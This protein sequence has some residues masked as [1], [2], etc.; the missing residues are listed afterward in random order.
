MSVG[1][2]RSAQQTET[3]RFFSDVTL[4][5]LQAGLRDL[6]AAGAGH[7]RQRSPVRGGRSGHG[8]R[9]IAV[10]DG[11]FRYG[12]WR[13][14]TAIREADTDGNP[15][16][17][18]VPGWTP[19]LVTPPYPDWPSGLNGVFGAAATAL[20][21]LNADGRVDLNL[22]SVAAG[23]TR[24]YDLAATS[25]NDAVDARVFSGIHFRTADEVAFDMGA[26]VANWAL[27]HHFGPA[28]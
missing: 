16:T 2:L 28:K 9:A 8:R 6:A 13:P 11:K 12:W 24:H 14:I 15:S 20:S 10:W 5:P 25:E 22:T 26:Q 27:D 1:S 23:V 3:A 18:G 17:V 7:Q 19:L 4:G 21:R